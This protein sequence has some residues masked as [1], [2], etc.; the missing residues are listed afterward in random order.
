MCKQTAV[1]FKEGRIVVTVNN[2]LIQGELYIDV[3]ALQDSSVF[4]HLIQ[5]LISGEQPV[6]RRDLG[7]RRLR[8]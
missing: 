6:N 5:D 8:S 1:I 3:L 7:L 4:L 2:A